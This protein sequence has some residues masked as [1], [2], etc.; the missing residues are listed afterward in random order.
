M[1]PYNLANTSIEK[2]YPDDW[3]PVEY[4]V[5]ESR[6]EKDIVEDFQS[7]IEASAGER[8]IDR[9]ISDNPEILTAILDLKN[10][11]HHAAWVIPKKV[12]RSHVSADIPGLIPDFLVGGRNSYGITWYVVELKGAQHKLFT[13]S[14]E[15]LYLSNVANKGLCQVLE[16]M[17]FCNK[18]QSMLREVLKLNGFVSAEA[19]LFI[20]REHET[21]GVR[22]RDLKSAFNN[23]NSH[24]EVRSYD[25]L[26]R[27]CNRI[28]GSY[29]KRKN[30]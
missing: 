5:H 23:I 24:L 19:F 14:N 2:R 4:F 7:L 12:I 15:S 1:K 25:A 10:T 8:D 21:E 18:S 16:Y 26:L 6:L 28:I 17:H 20:G 9:Y 27:C 30:A 3:P 22:E 11:G 13:K 29:K